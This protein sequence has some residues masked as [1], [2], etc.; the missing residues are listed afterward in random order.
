MTIYK[1]VE[2]LLLFISYSYHEHRYIESKPKRWSPK[3]AV[4]EK[5]IQDMNKMKMMLCIQHIN[6]QN[7]DEMNTRLSESCSSRRRYLKPSVLSTIFFL[8]KCISH[9]FTRPTGECPSFNSSYYYHK[10]P[11]QEEN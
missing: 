10:I 7:A 5:E 9:K 8:R 3:H 11:H 4:L 6:H 2:I 1:I